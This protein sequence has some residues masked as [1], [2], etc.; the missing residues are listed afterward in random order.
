MFQCN[1]RCWV[2]FQLVKSES[3]FRQILYAFVLVDE[4]SLFF[5][6]FSLSSF[7]LYV[8][9]HFNIT[10]YQ[11]QLFKAFHDLDHVAADLVLVSVFLLS[12]CISTI[13]VGI[14]LD[15]NTICLLSFSSSSLLNDFGYV[16]D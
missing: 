12:H 5:F 9:F 10:L 4:M 1:V 2:Y 11:S 16:L 6:A 3:F 8:A 13:K 15:W 14:E 7:L